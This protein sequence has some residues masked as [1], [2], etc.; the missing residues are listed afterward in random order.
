MRRRPSAVLARRQSP[1]LCAASD[2]VRWCRSWPQLA[3]GVIFLA[4]LQKFGALVNLVHGQSSGGFSKILYMIAIRYDC[5]HVIN[6]DRRFVGRVCMGSKSSFSREM[7]RVVSGKGLPRRFC[8]KSHSFLRNFRQPGHPQV[9]ILLWQRMMHSFTHF[10]KVS[11]A[12]RILLA[13]LV[14]TEGRNLRSFFFLSKCFESVRY[15]S[16][17]R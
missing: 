17:I 12:L 6:R 10:C 4:A 15:C 2:F 7:S 16:K 1:P 3:F 9:N 13:R 8:P 5:N 14:V 11:F